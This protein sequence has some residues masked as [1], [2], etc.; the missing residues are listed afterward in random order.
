MDNVIDNA[1]DFSNEQIQSHL[2]DVF[3]VENTRAKVKKMRAKPEEIDKPENP[4]AEQG[5]TYTPHR[6]MLHISRPATSD[7]A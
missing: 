6:S 3:A 7:G 4:L 1:E 2:F 5:R